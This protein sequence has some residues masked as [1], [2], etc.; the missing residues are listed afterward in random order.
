MLFHFSLTSALNGYEGLVASPDRLP[1]GTKP[2][3]AIRQEAQWDTDL[4][5]LQ[6]GCLICPPH[7]QLN[8][9]IPVFQ[10][11]I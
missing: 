5:W 7:G 1:A 8:P 9:Y 6:C 10:P 4:V 3:L 2:A 11:V